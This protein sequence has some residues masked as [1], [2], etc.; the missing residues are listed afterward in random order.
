[1]EGFSQEVKEFL[2]KALA[3]EPSA[4]ATCQELLDLPYF[5]SS[6][7]LE[8]ENELEES[9]SLELQEKRKFSKKMGLCESPEPFRREKS[10]I[11]YATR[12]SQLISEEISKR[13]SPTVPRKSKDSQ[14]NFLPD[15]HRHFDRSPYKRKSYRRIQRANQ[16]NTPD[17]KSTFKRK[18]FINPSSQQSP[19][20]S[21]YMA[22][23]IGP[24][25]TGRHRNL[26][27][28]EIKTSVQMENTSFAAVPPKQIHRR[29]VGQTQKNL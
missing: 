25:L 10:P 16:N 12:G 27:K 9:L 17:I 7:K 15:I 14:G 19:N 29:K 4:R 6:F 22:S 1:M 23:F 18:D 13:N 21:F 26:S 28:Q 20:E 11:G 8:F 2:V 3:Y 5:S 24:K